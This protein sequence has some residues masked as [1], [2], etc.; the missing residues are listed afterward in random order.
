MPRHPPRW[1]LPRGRWEPS[2]PQ[3]SLRVKQSRFGERVR[4][5]RERV[6]FGA[7]NSSLPMEPCGDGLYYLCTLAY[8]HV[9]WGRGFMAVS[10]G[11]HGTS[12]EMD[13]ENRYLH[14]LLGRVCLHRRNSVFKLKGVVR[15]RSASLC[16]VLCVGVVE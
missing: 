2:L 4:W 8:W 6:A 14:L 13:W 11:K 15:V 1:A 10:A 7:P 12:Q 5:E 3:P 9:I 16:S